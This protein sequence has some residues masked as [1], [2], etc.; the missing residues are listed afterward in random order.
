MSN[1]IVHHLPPD[2]P[3]DRVARA[4][5]QLL[6]RPVRPWAA[7]ALMTRSERQA[8]IRAARLAVWR[9]MRGRRVRPG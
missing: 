2:G 8:L 1:R 9:A 7:S 4:I 3:R 6:A 5:A